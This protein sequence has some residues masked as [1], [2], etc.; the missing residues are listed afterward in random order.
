MYNA[1]RATYYNLPAFTPSVTQ[2]PPT[3][4][5][6]AEMASSDL[7]EMR[8]EW[9]HREPSTVIVTGTFDHWSRS[10][11]LNRTN[12]GFVGSV[13]VPWAEKIKYKFIVDG[14]WLTQAG[15][16]T[17][18]D[19]GGYINNIYLTP[20][21]PA[22]A[23]A[24]EPVKLNND[25]AHE[26]ASAPIESVKPT[27]EEEEAPVPAPEK[28]VEIVEVTPKQE[29]KV[30]EETKRN[31]KRISMPIIP[32][33]AVEHNTIRSSPPPPAVP[34]F[35][36]P[37]PPRARSTS[38]PPVQESKPAAVLTPEPEPAKLHEVEVEP[39]QEE[40]II[41]TP[42]EV[43]IEEQKQEVIAHIPVDDLP[44]PKPEFVEESAKE[45]A[46][47]Q[48]VVVPTPEPAKVETTP[49]E[50][51][52]PS[53]APA[54]EEEK[55]T[56]PTPPA[57]PHSKE[58]ALS[59]PSATPTGS[60]SSSRFGTAASK[61]KRRSSFFGKIKELFSHDKEKEKEKVKK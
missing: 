40:P 35:V 27:E 9:P 16:P 37:P 43:S 23:S 7:Y 47:E 2:S 44:N 13:K 58:F 52:K 50:E 55:T 42:P 36:L 39:S 6:L 45:E 14:Q 19:P 25:A 60:P 41:A 57:T 5:S 24:P 48:L 53:P 12:S 21:K 4:N 61:K 22:A 17:E 56:L 46:E 33:N 59:S 34:D 15:Q 3:P 49:K 38:P 51:A 10:I 54:K 18:M 20:P 26:F 32:V 11:N 29:E 31:E 1:T 30:V 8:F 28:P